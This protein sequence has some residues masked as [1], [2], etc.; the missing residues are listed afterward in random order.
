MK[1]LLTVLAALTLALCPVSAAAQTTAL[2]MPVQ[3]AALSLLVSSSTFS[4][5]YGASKLRTKP[6]S[7]KSTSI[8]HT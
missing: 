7:K 6:I 4:A 8:T 3:N 5:M 2:V 1:I